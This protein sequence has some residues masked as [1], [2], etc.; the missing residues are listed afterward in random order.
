MDLRIPLSLPRLSR[1]LREWRHFKNI[2]TAKERESVIAHSW[3]LPFSPLTAHSIQKCKLIHYLSGSSRRISWFCAILQITLVEV[4]R[5]Q[6]FDMCSDRS[7]IVMF[8]AQSSTYLR[9]ILT[10]WLSTVSQFVFSS[11]SL[12][13]MI[14]EV[15]H[16]EM[17][18][19]RQTEIPGIITQPHQRVS[20]TEDKAGRLSPYTAVVQAFWFGWAQTAS[21][22]VLLHRSANSV[23]RLTNATTVHEAKNFWIFWVGIRYDCA[24]WGPKCRCRDIEEVRAWPNSR[25][26]SHA[27]MLASVY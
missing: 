16:H 25:N 10:H 20:R 15:E 26:G 19:G 11:Y 8:D 17:V 1:I 7:S 21:N 9:V 3:S 23:L 13:W 24:A 27:S 14:H 12:T 4:G 18:Y 2:L 6:D 5:T 22:V